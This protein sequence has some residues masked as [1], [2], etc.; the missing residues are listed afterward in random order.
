[1]A[2]QRGAQPYKRIQSMV[3]RMQCH[4]ASIRVPK[5]NMG[6]EYI[7]RENHIK[8]KLRPGHCSDTPSQ[9]VRT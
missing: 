9:R 5:V 3:S 2:A 6:K 8:T 4:T 7:R 1:M